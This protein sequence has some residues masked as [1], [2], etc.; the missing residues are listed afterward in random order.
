MSLEKDCGKSCES[1]VLLQSG[2]PAASALHSVLGC[3]PF[4]YLYEL[5]QLSLEVPQTGSS[6]QVVV[7]AQNLIHLC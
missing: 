1:P 3:L 5:L 2:F 7:V 4:K 6:L